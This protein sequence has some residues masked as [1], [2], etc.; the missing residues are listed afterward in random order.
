VRELIGC[1]PDEV[2]FLST[3]VIG[4][5]LPV[6][7]I[8]DALPNLCAAASVNGLGDF[9]QAIMTTD[10]VPKVRTLSVEDKSAPP[11]A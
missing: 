3:G 8:L 11:F 1:A 7:K 6:E 9:A 10:L 2:L 4:A 5:R